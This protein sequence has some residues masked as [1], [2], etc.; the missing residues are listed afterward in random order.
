[1]EEQLASFEAE[2]APPRLPALGGFCLVLVRGFQPRFEVG[3]TY[4]SIELVFL[5]RVCVI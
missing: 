4:Y 2:E 3:R 5:F 1:M